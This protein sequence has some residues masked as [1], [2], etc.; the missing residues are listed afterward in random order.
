R[1][2]DRIAEKKSLVIDEADGDPESFKRA[3]TIGYAGVS[4]KN[5]KGVYKSLLNRALIERYNQGGDFTFQTGEDLSLMP[6]VP[7]HQDFAAL[8]LLGIEHCERN[9]HHYSYGLS[10][11]T[12]EEKAMMLRDHPDLYVE[13]R[14][15][16]FLNIVEGQVNCASIQQ[17]P[18]FGVKTLPDWGAMEP[19]RTWIDTHYPA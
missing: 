18:G 10:H 2:I 8:G 7:L 5:C 12:A 17:V 1:W 9:G 13:R 6:I 14:D 19:M 4:H 15:E 3:H 16:V 11:L